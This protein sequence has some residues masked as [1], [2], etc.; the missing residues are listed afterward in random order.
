[1]MQSSARGNKE[2]LTKPTLARSPSLPAPVTKEHNVASRTTYKGDSLD[3]LLH[4]KDRQHKIINRKNQSADGFV[5]FGAPHPKLH[6]NTKQ[7]SLVLSEQTKHK[8]PIVIAPEV[9]S[10]D[11][12]LLKSAERLIQN[13]LQSQNVTINHET[14]QLAMQQNATL[15][16][17][18]RYASLLEKPWRIAAN[19]LTSDRIECSESSTL[20]ER[21][22]PLEVKNPKSYR[23]SVSSDGPRFMSNEANRPLL[24]ETKEEEK[25]DLLIQETIVKERQRSLSRMLDNKSIFTPNNTELEQSKQAL[26]EANQQILALRRAIKAYK[27]TK[28]ENT[29]ADTINDKIALEIDDESLSSTNIDDDDDNEMV[30]FIGV[31]TELNGDQKYVDRP[32]E[33]IRTISP[34][35]RSKKNSSS[36]NTVSR[37][38]YRALQI[39]NEQLLHTIKLYEEQFD[40]IGS[41]SHSAI[42]ETTGKLSNNLGVS[43][44]SDEQEKDIMVNIVSR[45]NVVDNET[46]RQLKYM[47]SKIAA[48]VQQLNYSE[49]KCKQ[50]AETDATSKATIADLSK[51]LTDCELKA[52]E[53]NENLMIQ[54]EQRIDL[55]NK[56][57]QKMEQE[58]KAAIEETARANLAK[59]TYE[60]KYFQLERTHEE[61]V[62]TFTYELTKS[63]AKS[64]RLEDEVNNL[65]A[66]SVEIIQHTTDKQLLQKQLQQSECIVAE[67]RSNDRSRLQAAVADVQS[68]ADARIAALEQ[69]LV[70]ANFETEAATRRLTE[71]ESAQ[72]REQSILSEE[73]RDSETTIACLMEEIEALKPLIS[74]KTAMEQFMKERQEEFELKQLEIAESKAAL[75]QSECEVEELR[76]ELQMLTSLPDIVRKMQRELKDA[77]AKLAN[78]KSSHSESNKSLDSSAHP[79]KDANDMKKLELQ[80]QETKSLLSAKEIELT[81]CMEL[82]QKFDELQEVYYI[83]DDE[84]NELKNQI[85]LMQPLALDLENAEHELRI[86]CEKLDAAERDLE[87]LTNELDLLKPLTVDLDEAEKELAEARLQLAEK[88]RELEQI[89]CRV[90][91]LQHKDVSLNE[92]GDNTPTLQS[93]LECAIKEL[94]ELRHELERSERKLSDID[95]ERQ[96]EKVTLS[97]LLRISEEKV[98]DL[99]AQLQSGNELEANELLLNQ[100][101]S[102]MELRNEEIASLERILSEKEK[103]ASEYRS[104]ISEME[105]DLQKKEQ[106]ILELEPLV[107]ELRC[108][109]QDT[110]SRSTQIMLEYA[111]LIPERDSLR[112]RVAEATSKIDKLEKEI[113]QKNA[114]IQDLASRH[115]DRHVLESLQQEHDRTLERCS[116]LS[117]QLAESQFTIGQLTE[118]LRGIQ[119]TAIRQPSLSMSTRST[120]TGTDTFRTPKS[121]QSLLNNGI[122]R[123]SS[124]LDDSL[125]S[126]RTTNL[127]PATFQESNSLIGNQS[128]GSSVPSN[129]NFNGV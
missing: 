46:S 55:A 121:F 88:S 28:K 62:Q 87:A 99:N 94:T 64:K 119:R 126:S 48:L 49:S 20:N 41:A 116:D 118:Q 71:L 75:A 44:M 4:T 98:F 1:M 102:E 40:Q 73:L 27:D 53:F 51:M 112:K 7:H 33:Y 65:M 63:E 45:L 14:I 11:D 93:Q 122:D 69:S 21:I 39:R 96:Q 79:N 91:E 129:R 66:T 13:I 15:Q 70:A 84:I 105:A 107:D 19:P 3:T 81:K 72:A 24:I 12:A 23:R 50:L 35:H 82:Q 76:N 59:L 5:G 32:P 120:N 114:M 113:E 77:Q 17:K 9:S 78:Q 85:D 61:V 111:T 104:L 117:L 67:L 83:A 123:I 10:K 100:L 52:K 60:T 58:S 95:E 108:E 68:Q 36:D 34:D 47:E 16:S 101:Q 42:D 6:R 92:N 22:K 90:V 31:R 89:Q 29:P 127:M 25:Q 106:T 124:R 56:A 54:T 80:L 30:A 115:D 97:E 109:I 2:I 110:A 125:R 86:T 128:R 57:V 37:L 18:K 103:E 26:D 8:T 38:E 74:E 43:S